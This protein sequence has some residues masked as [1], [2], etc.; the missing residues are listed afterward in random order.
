MYCTVNFIIYESYKAAVKTV[1]SIN[2]HYSYS[3]VLIT[4]FHFNN[5]TLL[6]PSITGTFQIPV[7]T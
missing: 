2:N 4:T 7:R 6:R 3:T 5:V 1:M